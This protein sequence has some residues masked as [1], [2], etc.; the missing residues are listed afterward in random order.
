MTP[1][2]LIAGIGNVL[3]G[4]DGFGVVAA[5]ALG[6]RTLPAVEPAADLAARLAARLDAD[7]LHR[8]DLPRPTGTV[9]TP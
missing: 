8:R 7:L 2:V 4:D 6:A 5:E 1:R 3:A 9:P